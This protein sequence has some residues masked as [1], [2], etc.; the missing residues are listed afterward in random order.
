MLRS[1]RAVQR[2]RANSAR[3][4][5]FCDHVLSAHP[6]GV[7]VVGNFRKSSYTHRE[8]HDGQHRFEH[9]YRDNTVYFI[10][11]K[12]SDNSHAFASASAKLVFWDRFTHWMPH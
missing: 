5:R 4:G 1:S 10:T 6:G 12:V 2:S 7:E 3:R 11:S 9:W 8:Y